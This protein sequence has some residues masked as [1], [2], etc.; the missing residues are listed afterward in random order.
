[1]NKAQALIGQLESA[2][3][4]V[5]AEMVE[6][7]TTANSLGIQLD[8]QEPRTLEPFVLGQPIPTDWPAARTEFVSVL[9]RLDQICCCRDLKARVAATVEQYLATEHAE[10]ST[11]TKARDAIAA[12]ER[13][14]KGAN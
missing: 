4:K 12:L 11:L 10:S 2:L 6:T 13:H 14:I 8:Y 3:L 7:E 1:M 5:Q 9:D